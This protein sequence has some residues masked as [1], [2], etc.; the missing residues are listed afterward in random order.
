MGPEHDIYLGKVLIHKRLQDV[1]P[2]HGL[3]AIHKHADLEGL[4]RQGIQ[5]LFV[6]IGGVI[7]QFEVIRK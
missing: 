7:N 2:Q 3:V 5:L 1:F 4:F 6:A